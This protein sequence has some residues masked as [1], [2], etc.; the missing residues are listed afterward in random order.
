[1]VTANLSKTLTGGEGGCTDLLNPEWELPE[2]FIRRET[3]LEAAD[4]QT[5][6]LAGQSLVAWSLLLE[7][8]RVLE[9]RTASWSRP[10]ADSP[11][12]VLC[13]GPVMGRL[14]GPGADRNA[15]PTEL[16]EGT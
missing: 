5:E 8:S 3:F 16:L 14:G 11:P 4:G 10:V 1:M 9:V 7:G 15:V 2:R 6:S 12:G 13:V